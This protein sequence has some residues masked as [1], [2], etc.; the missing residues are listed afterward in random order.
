MNNLHE[1]L[2]GLFSSGQVDLVIG[3]E[4]GSGDKPRPA[5]IK[6]QGEIQHLVFDKSCNHNLAAY[7]TRPEI[8]ANSKVLVFLTPLSI[9][10]AL[11]LAGEH[12]IDKLNL[13]FLVCDQE[14][15]YQVIEGIQA[16]GA[17]AGE[18]KVSPAAE[19]E[20]LLE[21]L[22]KM[23]RKERFEFWKDQL[24]AC[25]KCYACRAACPMCYCTRCTVEVNQPQW[26]SVPSTLQGN[27][28][29]HIMRAMHMAGRCVDC[30]ACE[31][32][33][34]LNIPLNLITRRM[35]KDIEAGFG[36]DIISVDSGNVLNTF[37]PDD[38]ENFIK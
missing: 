35:I 33:C 29:Y 17:F 31:K 9:R 13:K 4:R 10:S 16:L 32:A 19:S 37:R 2:S 26:I 5:F 14:K 3:Y 15:G 36:P 12:Q 27:F 1:I 7:L 38:K 34:P 28:E 22:D 21:R 30:G 11:R 8:V 18:V 25:I 24:S 23:S 6:A 20:E